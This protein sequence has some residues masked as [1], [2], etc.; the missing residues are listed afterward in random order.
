MRAY[1]VASGSIFVLI[2]LVHV[3]RMFA[4]GPQVMREPIFV[5]STVAAA[6]L[7]GWAFRL[8]TLSHR[9]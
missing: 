3:L 5:L 7:A 4:D 2:V 8:L 1:L 6:A 9:T